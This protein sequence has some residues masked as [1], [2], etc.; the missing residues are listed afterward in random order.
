MSTLFLLLFLL[1]PF[2][3]SWA[4]T[5]EPLI[6]KSPKIQFHLDSDSK[7]FFNSEDRNH[8]FKVFE[9][10]NEILPEK[11]RSSIQI[12][13]LI[14]W[15][16][17]DSSS[18]LILPFCPQPSQQKKLLIQKINS[19]LRKEWSD[20]LDYETSSQDIS[21]T[22]STIYGFYQY[23][24]LLSE[25][26][27]ISLNENFIP[28]LKNRFQTEKTYA[29]GHRSIDRLFIATII[30]ELAHAYDRALGNFSNSDEF[31]S[32][33]QWHPSAF[34]DFPKNK[35]LFHS[36][37]PYEITH[38]SEYFAVN[39]E[40]F[41]LDPEYACRRPHLF[42]YFTEHF[43]HIPF[44]DRPHCQ[45]N[46]LVPDRNTFHPLDLNPEHVYQVH[47]MVAK[48]SSELES[49][50]GHAMLRIVSCSP[51][52]HRVTAECLDDI[53]SHTVIGYWM[54]DSRSEP[55]LFDAFSGKQ[56]SQPS[57]QSFQSILRHYHAKNRD[58]IS[59]P[60]K[61]TQDEI[62]NLID[63]SIEMT[64]GYQGKYNLLTNNSATELSELMRIALPRRFSFPKKMLTGPIALMN[65]FIYYQVADPVHF[66]FPAIDSTTQNHFQKLINLKTLP[67]NFTLSKYFNLN[68]E[69][70]LRF[71]FASEHDNKKQIQ[72]HF[73]ALEKA[74]QTRL[75]DEI[76][77]AINTLI[78]K[79]ENG[80]LSQKQIQNNDVFSLLQKIAT[81]RILVSPYLQDN[82]GYGIPIQFD[83]N[84]L[85]QN[86]NFKELKRLEKEINFLLPEIVP[87]LVQRLNESKRGALILSRIDFKSHLDEKIHTQS[88]SRNSEFN[89][90]APHTGHSTRHNIGRNPQ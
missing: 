60:L 83:F 86:S 82:L 23:N 45:I 67:Q 58:I 88:N 59:I 19:N 31:R 25:F 12:P 69:E 56:L 38:R 6:S 73:V 79:A 55:S 71:F 3:P 28:I 24:P 81:L 63:I 7:D 89:F 35:N 4:F 44:S 13:V 9:N 8:L 48:G 76:F 29:C 74:L 68:F 5:V 20:T 50:A 61:L 66:Y 51:S 1:L 18:E 46:T 11:I 57:L 77:D 72:A 41:L 27:I 75:R 49:K 33:I 70:R 30:H 80:E 78:Y 34:T 62:R 85:S 47:Y 22:N 54:N 26:T 43:G 84:E 40:F 2:N 42:K 10:I 21:E 16:K 37:D 52:R 14:R 90:N 17:F 32:L 87:Q 64:W 39:L 53:E 15:K 65:D 36:P